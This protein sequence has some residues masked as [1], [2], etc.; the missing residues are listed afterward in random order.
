VH[1]AVSN[2]YGTVRQIAEFSSS[3]WSCMSPSENFVV[4]HTSVSSSPMKRQEDYRRTQ[5]VRRINTICR[6][7]VAQTRFVAYPVQLIVAILLGVSSIRV[8]SIGESRRLTDLTVD[9]PMRSWHGAHGA[10][11][12]HHGARSTKHKAQA[13][14]PG[15]IQAGNQQV[16]WYRVRYDTVQHAVGCGLWAFYT[17]YRHLKIVILPSK[18]LFYFQLFQNLAKSRI[19]LK[20][21]LIRVNLGLYR[22]GPVRLSVRGL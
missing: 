3:T 11:G 21:G 13:K 9:E 10:H 18:L 22:K 6:H 4:H 19:D 1:N 5:L 17:D 14:H 20:Y 8:T 16:V 2:V 15:P 12:A 7:L